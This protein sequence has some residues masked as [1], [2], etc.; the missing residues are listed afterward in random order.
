[1]RIVAPRGRS[2]TSNSSSTRNQTQNRR[3][4]YTSKMLPDWKSPTSIGTIRRYSTCT[5]FPRRLREA[6]TAVPRRSEMPSSRQATTT[7]SLSTGVPSRPCPG[8]NTQCRMDLALPDMW[9]GS[10]SS[11]CETMRTWKRCMWLDLVW[12]QNSPGSLVKR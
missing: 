5:D 6:R 11:C 3:I 12:E 1:M 7:S 8:T 10:S 2:K 4:D 9:P